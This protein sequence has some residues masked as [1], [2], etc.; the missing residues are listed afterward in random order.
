MSA[1]P[2]G[3]VLALDTSTAVGSV[4]LGE[5]DALLAE[6]TVRVG[7]GH[8][9]M[10]MPAVDALFR[11]LGREREELAG[12]VVAGG[13]GSFTGLRI[14]AAT[15]KGIAHALHLPLWAYSGLLAAAAGCWS[16]GR[17]VCS[18]FDARHR[19]VFGAC[20]AFSDELAE[21]LPPAALTLDEVLGFF[22]DLTVQPLFTGDGAVRHRAEI[23]QELGAAV[24]PLHLAGPRAATLLWL[25]RA[26]PE[27]GFVADPAAW[28]P[29]YLRASGAE[30]IAA[31]RA[32]D[33]LSGR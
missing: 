2:D 6:T 9:A 29:E 17:H 24:A 22:R 13:P 12:V 26:L 14:A 8:S 32:V 1:A 28:E 10:L 11:A 19:D 16:P 5:G 15:A 3:L 33:A 7:T 31:Q 18:L 21:L 30:R 20:Y 25:A 23:E 27:R 4:A